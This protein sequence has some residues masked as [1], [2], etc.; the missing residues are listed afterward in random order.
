M[1]LS[2]ENVLVVTAFLLIMIVTLWVLQALHNR[3]KPLDAKDWRYCGY[4]GGPTVVEGYSPM[5]APE[6]FWT[7][8]HCTRI[9][10]NTVERS[11]HDWHVIARDTILPEFDRRTGVKN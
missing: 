11:N 7:V 8:I 9:R 6:E 10:V 1:P 3:G 2:I 5:A 4:C